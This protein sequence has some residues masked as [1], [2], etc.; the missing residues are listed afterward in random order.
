MDRKRNRDAATE[1]PI[2]LVGFMGAGKTTVGQALADK[3]K[4]DFIDLDSVI[5]QQTGK[6]IQ[7][8]FS[9][10][11]EPEFRQIERRAIQSCRELKNAVVALGGGAY[12][13]EENRNVLRGT[14]ITIWLDCPLEICFERVRGD[15]S[16]P[17]VGSEVEMKALFDKRRPAYAL[18]DYVVQTGSLSP[19]E[20]ALEIIRLH[21]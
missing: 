11:G 14:G 7:Q 6:S 12:L 8:I 16:R 19:D 3:L 5:Q 9:E 17:L 2:F 10:Q 15:G 18:A 13:A 4:C 21:R 20:I 1:K